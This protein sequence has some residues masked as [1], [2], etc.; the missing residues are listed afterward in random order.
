MGRTRTLA[1]LTAV[2]ALAC[3]PGCGGGGGPRSAA[4]RSPLPGAVAVAALS[5]VPPAGM[6]RIT[7]RQRGVA[8][9]LSRGAV[10][11]DPGRRVP[12]PG[13]QVFQE[14]RDLG[15][16]AL[17]AEL[18]E[19]MIKGGSPDART[20][21]RAVRVPGATEAAVL[22]TTYPQVPSKQLD[23]VIGTPSGPQYDIRYGGETSAYDEAAARR[24]IATARVSEAA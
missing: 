7:P 2:L 17:R 9:E 11:A 8:L 5:F 18:I 1:V 13:V 24:I 19:D 14:G 21:G 15:G 10:A 16:V 23:V 12:P 22:E 20:T 3:C 4:G 6:A